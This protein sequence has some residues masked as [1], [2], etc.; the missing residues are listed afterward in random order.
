MTFGVLQG[1]DLEPMLYLLFIN[2][3]GSAIIHSSYK[4]YADGTVLYSKCTGEDNAALYTSMQYD[5]F[6]VVNWCTKNA[7]MMKKKRKKSMIF[8]KRQNSAR[9]DQRSFHVNNRQLEIVPFYKYLCTNLDSELKQ[10]NETI[11]SISYKLYFLKRIK[12]F[13][14]IKTHC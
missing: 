4:L 8:G 2:D 11:K 3:L 6:A 5:L 13:L 7:I 9:L 14:S 1:L 10:S 12:Q